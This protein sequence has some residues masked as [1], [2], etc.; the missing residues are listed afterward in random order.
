MGIK[1][2]DVETGLYYNVTRYYDPKV[3][4]FI[5]SDDILYLD[6]ETIGCLIY[7]LIA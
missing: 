6:P 7:M 5:S 3:G 2:S 4:R 1:R